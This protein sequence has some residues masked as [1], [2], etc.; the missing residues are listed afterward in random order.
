MQSIYKNIA[1]LLKT[2]SILFFTGMISFFK[3]N[4]IMT[5]VLLIEIILSKNGYIKKLYEFYYTNF[6]IRI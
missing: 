4:L 3:H 5:Y 6:I 2:F 1:T